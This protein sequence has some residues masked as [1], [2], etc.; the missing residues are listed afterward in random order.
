[1]PWWLVWRTDR[2]PAYGKAIQA[3][4]PPRAIVRHVSDDVDARRYSESLSGA[5]F[6]VAPLHP[7]EFT[8][9]TAVIRC[10]VTASSAAG[11]TPAVENGE[12]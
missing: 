4:S 10:V 5:G 7:D 3:E 6:S 2:N 12:G 11:V 1:M 8:H 9:H